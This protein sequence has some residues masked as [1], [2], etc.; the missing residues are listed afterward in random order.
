MH[1][2]SALMLALLGRPGALADAGPWGGL[3]RGRT[4]TTPSSQR[5]GPAKAS[6]VSPESVTGG[7]FGQLHAGVMGCLGRASELRQEKGD[8]VPA[9]L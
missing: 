1:P 2:H 9:L 8:W 5:Y 3:P 4:G 6:L 7:A